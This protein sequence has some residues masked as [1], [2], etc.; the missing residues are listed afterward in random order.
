M[1]CEDL[2]PLL[3]GYVDGELP[4]KDRAKVEEHVRTCES[5]AHELEDLRSL[6]EELGAMEFAEPTDAQL[7]RYWRGVYNRLERK[8]GWTLFTVG[9]VVLLCYG[10]FQLVEETVTDPQCAIALKVG[11]VAIV[12]GAVVLF[13]SILRE[14]LAIRKHDR[15]SR[16]VDR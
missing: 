8:L 2:K 16:E 11:V 13:V 3:A 7:A 4:A 12:A 9:A 10:G 14:R 1:T 6:S 5:C 15:Y